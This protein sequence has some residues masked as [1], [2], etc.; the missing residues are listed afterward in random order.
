MEGNEIKLSIN[1]F[2]NNHRRIAAGIN[3]PRGFFA[4]SAQ[5]PSDTSSSVGAPMPFSRR[6]RVSAVRAICVESCADGFKRHGTFASHQAAARFL[7]RSFFAAPFS[8]RK[9]LSHVRQV[10]S[11]EN[12][13]VFE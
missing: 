13:R 11:P 2:T 12:V 5:I 6:D 8:I 1:L 7:V 9:V 4:P 10:R 3:L